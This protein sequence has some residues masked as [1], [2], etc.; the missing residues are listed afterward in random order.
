MASASPRRRRHP[1]RS[2]CQRSPALVAAPSRSRSQSV[3]ERREP[4]SDARAGEDLQD[5]DEPPTGRQA[6]AP[7]EAAVTFSARCEPRRFT[8]PHRCAQLV[9]SRRPIWRSPPDSSVRR[10]GDLAQVNAGSRR[11]TAASVR[12]SRATFRAA[13]VVPIVSNV[14]CYPA[15][16]VGRGRPPKPSTRLAST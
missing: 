13:K 5:R 7:S 15:I 11:L 12:R 2:V 3:L 8:A 6:K 14:G 9:V 10:T 16:R 1:Q 4:C